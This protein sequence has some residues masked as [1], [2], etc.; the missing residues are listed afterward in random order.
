VPDQGELK[1]LT[2]GEAF[3]AGDVAGEWVVVLSMAMN[4][5][6]TLDGRIHTA[7]NQGTPDGNYFFRL[8]CG[9]L[10]E[11]W[12]LFAIADRNDLVARV[13]DGMA[14]EA[15][16]AYAEV[17]ELFTRPEANDADPSPRSWAEQHLKEVRD[18]TFHYPSVG[19]EDLRTGVAA[20]RSDQARVGDDTENGRS[21][22]FDFADVG[23]LQTAFGN[24]SQPD[25]RERFEEIV[26]TA[27]EIVT[28]LVPVVWSALGTYLR[29][30][31]VDPRRLHAPEMRPP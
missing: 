29:A 22:P 1:P 23:A 16:D 15:K 19:G 31:K 8:L 18:R 13:V 10:R 14:S 24:I 9:T 30:Q 25:E 17:R 5:L 4:D 26:T 20:S 3:P 7:L 12:R 6:A 21:R 2:I 27:K 28:Q 11:L